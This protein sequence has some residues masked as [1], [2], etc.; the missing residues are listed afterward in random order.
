VSAAHASPGATPS[1]SAAAGPALQPSSFALTGPLPRGV[2]VLEAS[3]GTGKTYTIA[4]L[5][6]RFV[7]DGVPLERQLL[8]TFTR[9][10]TGELRERVRERLAAVRSGLEGALAGVPPADD[11]VVELLA[12]GERA[13]V[14]L[15]RDRLERALADFDAATIA[16]THGF[17]QEV[18]AGLGIAADLEPDVAFVEDLSELA[19]E[20]IADLYV[21]RFHGER[22]ARLSYGEV[23]A[24]AGAALANPDAEL[25]GPD[26]R[27]AAPAA[28]PP[29]RHEDDREAMRVRLAL[30]VRQEL[31]A[32]KRTLAV[33]TYDDLLT[34]LNEALTGEHAEATAARL[35]SR[36]DVVMVDEF[37]DT[38][39]VQ[40]SIMRRAFAEQGAATALVLIA[41]PKQAIYAFRGADVYSYLEAAR[42]AGARTTLDTNWRSDQPLLDAYDALFAG[43]HLG[44]PEIVYRSVRAAPGHRRSRL[45]G[46][47][48]PAPL[49]FRVLARERVVLTRTGYAQL[50]AAREH[51]VADL[52][53][54][55]VRL[56]DCA[57]R[58]ERRDLGG[59]RIATE[60]LRPGHVA[61]LVATNRQAAMARQA[62]AGAGVPAVTAGAGSVF[63]TSA[64]HEWLTLLEAL[65]RPSLAAGAHAA[66]LG[67]FFGWP[68]E[69]LALASEQDLEALHQRLHD[70]A[71][72]LR[73][74]G[75]A[76]LAELVMRLER[77]PA[78]ALGERDGERTL[79]DLRHVGELLHAQARESGLGASAL[80]G[81]LRRRISQAGSEAGDE[82]R[83]RRL[84]SDA[85][86][87]QV[88]TVH[89]SK[90]LEF[91]VVCL[92]FLWDAPYDSRD[93]EPIVFHNPQA[94]DR[95]QLDVTLDGSAYRAHR[96]QHR[97]ERRGEELRLAYVALTRACQQAI[98]WWAG[99]YNSHESALGRLLFC[100][101]ADGEVAPFAGRARSDQEVR[102]RLGRLADGVPGRI[103]VEE[104]LL[105]LPRSLAPAPAPE[106][107]LRVASFERA[108]DA[109]W[110]RT[111][112]SDITR[113]A[114]EPLVASE[115]E[116]P[117]IDD[118]EGAGL[119]E[120]AELLIAPPAREQLPLAAMAAGTRAGT[121]V[122]R[123]LEE[124]DFAAED[125]DGEL[126]RR[127][128]ELAGSSSV[129]DDL[130]DLEAVRTGLRAVIETPLGA[131]ADERALRSFARRDRLDELAFEL[132]LAGGDRPHGS[133]TLEQLAA[134]LRSHLEPGDPLAAYAV[135]LGDP[136]LL[137][138]L[139][140]YLTG[141]LDL[142]LRLERGR[143]LLV[144]YKTNWLGRPGAAL[145]AL[146]HRPRALAAEMD[147]RH[148]VLQA[149][150]YLVALHRFL[151]WRVPGHDPDRDIAGVLYL[152]VRGML[153][154]GTPPADGGRCGVFA[155]R[156]APGLL[157]ALSDALDQGQDG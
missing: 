91:P 8:I 38:D 22:S 72:V 84:D 96:D 28:P 43:A 76:P 27:A 124:A 63:A 50:G 129:A 42:A 37:Q 125:L 121:F 103:S 66:A 35:S 17:C 18:L 34:R 119:E 12:R 143:F 88:L 26:G 118:E 117:L 122:H 60:P 67:R 41:D 32:R 137:R 74:G 92:P 31:E 133:F 112:Y 24:I 139:R 5:A 54:E 56:L 131:L 83:S 157:G 51:V 13:L 20:V 1:A 123:V 23:S 105:G 71:Q 97:R 115:P 53:G 155:W 19:E 7:A 55:I 79:T 113:Q 107:Q 150:L 3:A 87:V 80:T 82:A 14:A 4:A 73:A 25:V 134:V 61:V 36:F 69:R 95:R 58:L 109:R 108:L 77:L 106:P 94:G 114:H 52:A 57:A 81:W 30:R 62:L 156:P 16:T 138:Q 148:Y 89:R 101:Q 70:L 64:A 144:D 9:I 75:V 15:R 151:R 100:R 130:G 99:S 153:G 110:R 33:M 127:I 45:L 140:G 6:T 104:S 154:P 126:E 40:W 98:V 146:D 85:E 21:R 46:A 149:L 135:R 11:P 116:E 132:P 147:R 141:S 136:A 29:D 86:A 128:R 59:D 68:A 102:E 39:R 120:E 152:F 111:S 47:P 49:R 10:A 142:V 90:G 65:E 78:R 48:V 145:S 93:P 2:S 44:H